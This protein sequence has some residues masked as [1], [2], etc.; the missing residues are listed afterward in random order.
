MFDRPRDRAALLG[1]VGALVVVAL[2][3][4]PSALG[5]GANGHIHAFRWFGIVLYLSLAFPGLLNVERAGGIEE[6]EA[7]LSEEGLVRAHR[8]RVESPSDRYGNAHRKR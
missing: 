2:H 3:V 5:Y 1:F 4:V 8:S 6:W 7:Q